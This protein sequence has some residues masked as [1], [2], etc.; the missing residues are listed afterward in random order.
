MK[1]H[2][3]SE[4][5]HED[6]R[7]TSGWE[8]F[9]A[10]RGL[11]YE[12]PQKTRV[13]LIVGLLVVTFALCFTPAGMFT[14]GKS[15]VGSGGFNICLALIPVVVG[16]LI[17]GIVPGTLF[18]LTLGLGLL[19]HS[20]LMPATIRDS[21]FGDPL[22]AI[23]PMVVAALIAGILFIVF[24]RRIL[25]GSR[26]SRIVCITITCVIIAVG[27]CLSQYFLLAVS[28][29][30]LVN[31]TPLQAMF[32]TFLRPDRAAEEIV[33]A[34][35]LIIACVL[36][37]IGY[38]RK[39][40]GLWSRSMRAV[41]RRWLLV[42]VSIAFIVTM[43]ISYSYETIR[44]QSE[45]KTD[46]N[47]EIGY[48]EQQIDDHESKVTQLA[49]IEDSA[50]LDKAHTAATIIAA[51]PSVLASTD[52]M[53]QLAAA[54][55]LASL[56]VTDDS[57]MVIADAD[58]QGIGVYD[59]G[60]YDQTRQYMTLVSDV[61]ATVVEQPRA[62]LDAS[63]QATDGYS[64]F[65]GVPR[66]DV[67]GI[68][69]VSIPASDY[70]SMISAASIE[71]LGDDYTIGD[72]GGIIVIEN[73]T[74][75]TATDVEARGQSID[76]YLDAEEGVFDSDE[77]GTAYDEANGTFAFSR[78]ARYGD[79]L[80]VDYIPASEVYASR[81]SIMLWNTIL[82]LVLFGVVF[83]LAS[84]LLDSVVIDGIEKTNKTLGRITG[85]DLNQ[86]VDVHSNLEFDSLSEGINTTV[87]AL[88]DSI[89]EASARI[90]RE[91]ATARAIQGSAIPRTFPPFPEIED[92]DIYASMNPAREVGGDFYDFFL[93]DRDHLGFV[94]ADVSGKGIPAAL[95]MMTAKT[96]IQNYMQSAGDLAGSIATV[97][98]HLCMGND[99][100]MFV[101][102]FLA[103][104]D[105][106]TGELTYVNAGHN[107]P[108]L[109]HDG[110]WEWLRD[111]SG[112][113]LG[114]MDDRP[115]RAYTRTIEHG[116]ELLL[117]TDGVTEAWS[118][119][120]E[121]YGEDRLL[122]FL[123]KHC[124][125]HPTDLVDVLK[126]ELMSFEKGIDQADD[127]TMLALEYG[128]APDVSASMTIPAETGRLEQML[129][130]VHGE[131]VRR[132]CPIKTQKQLDIALEELFV[133]IAHYAY[134]DA[135]E[136]GE[137]EVSYTYNATPPSITVE[138]SDTGIPYNPL[139]RSDPERPASVD[140]APIGGL[141]IMMAKRAVDE[142]GYR[143][144][145]GHNIVTL[146]KCW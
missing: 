142:I 1:G 18:G 74:I 106:R 145:D 48:L 29:P 87:D 119:A 131:L 16:A 4:E 103:I 49:S 13:L 99:A 35:I 123:G 34:I 89:A 126:D 121:I 84:R 61:T 134:P 57:G 69:Q 76:D 136:P 59:F 101:T 100:E 83:I 137:V 64:L 56:T 96:E 93:I 128:E 67:A 122:D 109:R 116:D 98:H 8:R 60:A 47:S 97:N 140:D 2:R 52:S 144:E 32:R 117:Y 37:V 38:R 135:A 45:A 43:A 92:F 111:R 79:Y 14:V 90:D 22:P 10:F 51:Q 102:A 39:L 127:I 75:V 143:H 124:D 80:L 68:I 46:L 55:G 24:R 23:V 72:G 77:M 7:V 33:T 19:L 105:F 42:F 108:L 5:S 26:S 113:F 12:T 17:L 63:G 31:G 54:L 107:P 40:D 36:T 88:K 25:S 71:H 81:G 146:R 78:M 27:Y 139:E 120:G 50:V 65:A 73:G 112:F 21:F 138:L 141:G 94:I 118:S 86:K 41:F 104:L 133:N 30:E 115:Y 114:A 125:S 9:A 95:F 132:L 91:L 20:R 6:I 62:S 3:V 85:G 11:M 15:L 66:T 44:L 58:G 129:G 53:R 28:N 130:F 70:E 110:Q 82:Y